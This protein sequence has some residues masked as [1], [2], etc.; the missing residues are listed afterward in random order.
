VSRNKG[1]KIGGSASAVVLTAIGV[2]LQGTIHPR[3]ALCLYV[4][5]L[6]SCVFVVVQWTWVQKILGIYHEP[7][8]TDQPSSVISSS[9]VTAPATATA[10]GNVQKIEQHFHAIPSPAL[11]ISSVQPDRLASD[12]LNLEFTVKPQW[13][14]L[15]Y[16]SVPGC[17][18]ESTPSDNSPRRSL[19]VYFTRNAPAKGERT[20]TA[21]SLVPILK[22]T[23]AAGNEQI[24][25]AYWLGRT[26]HEVAFDV[27]HHEAVVIGSRE[28]P[29][30]ASYSNPHQFDGSNDFFA[31][32]VRPCGDRKAMPPV[33][34]IS[35]EISLYDVYAKRTI[36]QRSFEISISQSS[37][38]ART[39]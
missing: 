37:V 39:L 7:L 9:T 24:P 11:P 17:W 32:P 35:V 6:I 23:H 26:N 12:E 27:G 31:V 21:I 2:Y 18:R 14:W 30:F 19:I 8:I 29:L 28:G 4:F 5:A 15:V 25:R 20:T 13:V 22:F 16:E 10:T 34:P 38:E 3:L 1:R 33:A 36:E